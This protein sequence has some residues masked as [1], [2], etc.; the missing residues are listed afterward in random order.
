MTRAAHKPKDIDAITEAVERG[1][2][3]SEIAQLTG[4]TRSSVAGM[5]RRW[6]LAEKRP[7]DAPYAARQR[8]MQRR[9]TDAK[10]EAIERTRQRNAA[11]ARLKEEAAAL[12]NTP[13]TGPLTCEGVPDQGQCKWIE[14]NAQGQPQWCACPVTHGIGR[15]FERSYCSRHLVRVIN[16]EVKTAG[17][18]DRVRRD[19][20]NMSGAFKFGTATR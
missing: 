9:M 7:P 17:E 13:L 19:L 2:S 14:D 11:R 3:F 8:A 10:A 20:R 6:G 15:S 16:L 5:I 1:L 18:K 4:R 12:A